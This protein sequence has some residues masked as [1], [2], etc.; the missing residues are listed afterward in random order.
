MV[1]SIASIPIDNELQQAMLHSSGWLETPELVDDIVSRDLLKL[2]MRDRNSIQ[3]EIHGVTNHFHEETPEFLEASLEELSQELNRIPDHDPIK[4]AYLDSQVSSNGQTYV[5][6][7][8]F[9]LRFLRCELF[10]TRKAARRMLNFLN[11]ACHLFGPKILER[12]IKI[13][14]LTK[15]DQKLLRKGYIQVLPFRDR[16][17]RPIISW[18]GDFGVAEG[19]VQSRHRNSLYLLWTMSED[20]ESQRKGATKLIW[21]INNFPRTFPKME[22]VEYGTRTLNAMPIRISAFHFCVPDHPFFHIMR[23]MYALIMQRSN[24]LFRLQFHVGEE[25]ELRYKL[26]TYGMPV[27]SIPVTGSGS[28][29]TQHLKQWIQKRTSIDEIGSDGGIVECPRSNDVVFRTGKSNMCNPGNAMFF[30]LIESRMQEHSA[31]TQ[32]ERSE[33][34]KSIIWT[35][36]NSGGRFLGWDNSRSGWIEIVGMS[37]IHK[38][39]AN[40]VKAFK[41]RSTATVQQTLQSSTDVFQTEDNRKRRKLAAHSYESMDSA[42]QCFGSCSL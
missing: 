23:S 13:T 28:I 30:N 22:N 10:D 7:P 20:V 17:G 39:V 26:K 8:D 16:S 6:R 31:A 12:P 33:I 3:E 9:R 21:C 4:A 5:Y 32:L 35:I 24:Y 36:R 11:H 34:T 29:K 42:E 14:D 1:V 40:R 2:S 27:E 41:S 25:I 15:E 19:T 38:K 18:L 37:Q